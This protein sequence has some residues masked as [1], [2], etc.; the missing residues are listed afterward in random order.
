MCEKSDYTYK[1]LRLT[2]LFSEKKKKKRVSFKLLH[3]F[4]RVKK[5]L[6]TFLM[7]LN[8]SKPHLK[9]NFYLKISY[10]R[11]WYL[12]KSILTHNM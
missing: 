6:G 1:V 10:R 2:A 7:L 3:F 4:L 5:Y 9:I 11:L 8:G 12:E